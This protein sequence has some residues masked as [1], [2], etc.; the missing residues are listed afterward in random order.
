MAREIHGDHAVSRPLA[1]PIARA[2]SSGQLLRMA[3][4]EMG[5][6][7][8]RGLALESGWQYAG[9]EFSDAVVAKA[10][11]MSTLRP[12][13]LTVLIDIVNKCNLRCI[14]CHFSFDEVFYQRGQLMQ[15]E[16]FASIVRAIRPYTRRLTLSAAYEPTSSPH[17][18]EILRLAGEQR[19]AELSFLTNGNLLNDKLLQAIADAGVTEVCVSVHAARAA[20]YAHILRGGALDKAIGNVEKLLALRRARNSALPRIQFN[21]ALM[22]SNLEELVEIIE[23]AGTLGVDAVAFRHLIVFEGLDMEAESLAGHDRQYVNR[24][25]RAALLRAQELG[26]SLTN[27]TDYFDLEGFE[28]SRQCVEMPAVPA[29]PE[30][31]GA[32]PSGRGLLARLRALLSPVPPAPAPMPVVIQ[33]SVDTPAGDLHFY[34]DTV[35]VS[36]WALTGEGLLEVALSRDP[37]PG[38][39]PERI[40]ADGHVPLGLACFHNGTRADVM[41]AYAGLPYAY[42]AGW[43]YTLHRHELPLQGGD[44]LTVHVIAKAKNGNRLLIGKRQVSLT[45]GTDTSCHVRCHKPFDSLYIDA[46]AH[47]Y[48]YPDCHTDQPFGEM[49]GQ[50]FED[51][52]HDPRLA[53]LRLDMVAGNAPGMCVRCPLF[54]NRDVNDA[55]TFAPHA[56]FSTEAKR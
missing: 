27:A 31:D 53:A 19:F 48:P 5:V 34:G 50:S 13:S 24:C 8:G 28:A 54:I 51:V 36:G 38:D 18:A 44:G 12:D 33:G 2:P 21:V 11:E 30:Q 23:L 40:N 20:T 45:A 10:R 35:E 17:F 43:S 49:Q 22:R 7:P 14:M 55:Q 32:G 15:P 56:D 6:H 39:A 1:D 42:R 37:V 29:A 47:V 16:T 52:W 9:G 41:R 26:V 4:R 46:R 3:P 25:I